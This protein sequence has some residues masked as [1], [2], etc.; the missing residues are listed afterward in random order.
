MVKREVPR[1]TEA[2]LEILGVLWQREASTV[3][4]VAC[5]RDREIVAAGAG[6]DSP[7]VIGER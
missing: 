2:E 6:R 3:R 1:P 7:L 4:G 5:R